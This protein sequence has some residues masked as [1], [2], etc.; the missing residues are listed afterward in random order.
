MSST[1]SDGQTLF[2]RTNTRRS[3]SEGSLMGPLIWVCTICVYPVL[4]IV[5]AYG[6]RVTIEVWKSV[7][8]RSISLTFFKCNISKTKRKILFKIIYDP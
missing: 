1:D 5:G 4:G 3:R 6:I 8:C 7:L 2:S